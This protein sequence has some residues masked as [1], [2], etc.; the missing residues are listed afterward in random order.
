MGLVVAIGGAWAGGAAA[1]ALA[2]AGII[3]GAGTLGFAAVQIGIA[4]VIGMAAAKLLTPKLPTPEGQQVN[5][6]QSVAYQERVY[7]RTRKGGPYGLI[8][9]TRVQFPNWRN[10]DVYVYTIILAAHQIKGAVDH[11][12]DDR[13]VEVGEYAG[14]GKPDYVLSSPYINADGITIT[15]HNGALDQAAD[16]LLV[17]EVDGWTAQHDMAGLAYGVITA[18]QHIDN[19]PRM[20]PTGRIPTWAPV[21]DGND[22]IL[23]PRTGERGFTRN[24]ALCFAHELVEYQGL[25]VD[26]DAVA[27]EADVCD[28]L[29]ITGEGTQRPRWRVGGTISD[30]TDFASVRAAFATAADA[31]LFERPDGKFGFY[32]GRWMEPQVS[33]GPRDFIALQIG[34]A[35]D[36]DTANEFTVRYV[37][38]ANHWKESPS[39]A[40]VHDEDGARTRKEISAYLVNDHHQACAIAKRAARADHAE[41]RISGTLNF[42][43]FDLIGHRFVSFSHPEMGVACVLE[44]QKLVLNADRMTWA[45]EGVSTAAADWTLLPDEEPARPEYGRID[46]GTTIDVIGSLRVRVS[47]STSGSAALVAEWDEQEG[48]YRQQLRYAVAGSEDWQLVDIPSGSQQHIMTG[49]LDGSTYEVQIRNIRSGEDGEWSAPVSALAVANT[50]APPALP[51]FEVTGGPAQ[52]VVDFDTPNTPLYAAARIFRARNSTNFANAVL[53][54]TVY[55]SP[56]ISD[57][58]TDTGLTAASYTYWGRAINQSGVPGPISN[59]VTVAVL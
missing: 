58:W 28:Q 22:Q 37:E 25:D 9:F 56:N 20:Y 8:H 53:V 23:D 30:E 35:R 24:W 59:P 27:L 1:T 48:N 45:F 57:G 10:V 34:M 47:R 44:I 41:Y 5:L 42:A 29:V 31:Y 54:Q 51:R 26:W 6:A 39:G 49:L 33:L 55:G 43:G 38:P 13:F 3:G 50:D 21:I 15:V 19:G 18:R 32:A 52:A 16:E 11:Y 12:L 4:T 17:R 2:T 14:R 40:F 36:M 46:G 7:G